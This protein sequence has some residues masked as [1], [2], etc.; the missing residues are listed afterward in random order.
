MSKKERKRA[1]PRPKAERFRW[2]KA[3]AAVVSGARERL[4]LSKAALAALAAVSAARISEVETCFAGRG[5][6]AALRARIVDALSAYAGGPVYRLVHAATCP[7]RL[8]RNNPRASCACS[9]ERVAVRTRPAPPA[10]AV[11]TALAPV[12]E[13]RPRARKG[14]KASAER[15]REDA[16]QAEAPAPVNER[17]KRV[18]APVA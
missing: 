2:T 1:K 12:S 7:V 6:N 18:K 9:P 8:T 17:P 13:A 4:G 14:G 11:P 16:A 10:V 5:P 3:E 15:R